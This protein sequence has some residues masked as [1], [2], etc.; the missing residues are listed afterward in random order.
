MSRVENIAWVFTDSRRWLMQRSGKIDEKWVNGF[1]TTKMN[2]TLSGS[3]FHLTHHSAF[4]E[5]KFIFGVECKM[6]KLADLQ[7]HQKNGCS[8]SFPFSFKNKKSLFLNKAIFFFT[9][10]L[11]FF[12]SCYKLFM[13]FSVVNFQF[14]CTLHLENMVKTIKLFQFN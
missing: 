11:H 6:E 5:L 13:E 3:V 12:S 10:I 14:S 9:N 8:Y 7:N 1:S 2:N 4:F